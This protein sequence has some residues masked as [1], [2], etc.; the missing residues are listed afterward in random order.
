MFGKLRAHWFEQWHRD[1]DAALSELPDVE[2]FPHELL[3]QLMTL[4]SGLP[5]RTVLIA[6]AGEPI[7]VAG[8]RKRGRM[9]EPITNWMA[10]GVL[11]P[12][13][14]GCAGASIRAIGSPLQVAWWRQQEAA[15]TGRHLRATGHET[16]YGTALDVNLEALWKERKLAKTLRQ[17]EKR[18]EGYTFQVNAPGDCEW[19]IRQWGQKWSASAAA[20]SPDLRDRLPAALYLQAAGQHFTLT[21]RD[22]ERIVAGNTVLKHGETLVGQAVYRDPEYEWQGVGNRLMQL[23]FYWARETGF[24]WIDI[25]GGNAYKERWAP[26]QSQWETFEY[27]PTSSFCIEGVR[28]FPRRIKSGLRHVAQLI[29]AFGHLL[30]GA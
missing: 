6:D 11:W 14:P 22:G 15:P 2:H 1:L 4:E 3:R 10:P 18:T 20:D 5:K 27:M 19:V 26:P 23:T 30:G 7:A 24:R 29:P 25:G 13:R 21:L 8:L 17:I 9:W 12:M 16:T 28:R